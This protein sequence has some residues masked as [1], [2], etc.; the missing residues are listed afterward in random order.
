MGPSEPG[1]PSG[2]AGPHVASGV[3]VTRQQVH[4]AADAEVL[5]TARARAGSHRFRCTARWPSGHRTAVGGRH[6]S[7]LV[8]ESIRQA[9]LCLAQGYFDVPGD[10]RFVIKSLAFTIDPGR[11]PAARGAATDLVMDV[12]VGDLRHDPATGQLVA[13]TMRAAYRTADDAE[14]FATAAGT[15]RLFTPEQ[16]TAVRAAPR[17]LRP[18]AATAGLLRRPTPGQ[19]AVARTADVVI[20]EAADGRWLIAPADPQHPFFFDH[21]ADHLPGMLLLEAA[22]QHALLQLAD[23][24][25]RLTGMQMR[26]LAFTEHQPPAYLQAAAPRPGTPHLFRI[27]QGSARVLEG[28]FDFAA[29]PPEGVKSASARRIEGT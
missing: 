25:L 3:P 2:P 14:V 21:P 8:A 10:T 11:E 20:A 12:D 26:P 23:P 19:V 29:A 7:L 5:I 22:R 1:P 15:A 16:Y 24:R 13:L 9:C 4:R 27:E 28:T 6:S 17:D 18:M